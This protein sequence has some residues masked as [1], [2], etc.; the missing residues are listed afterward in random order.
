MEKT[1]LTIEQIDAEIKRLHS[2]IS[3]KDKKWDYSKSFD[4]YERY[5]ADEYNQISTLD[6]MKRMMMPYELSELP[7]Y[8]DVMSLKD[9]IE[10]CKCGNFIDYDGHGYYVKDGKES[11]IMIHPSD[12]ID[13]A[14]RPDFDTIIWYNR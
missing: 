13:G 4:E 7:D 11:N 8:G 5:M 12:V 10:D 2:V 14:I 1:N 9:F 6:Q 3:E